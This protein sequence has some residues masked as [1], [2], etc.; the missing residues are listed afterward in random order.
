MMNHAPSFDPGYAARLLALESASEVLRLS[1][2]EPE[3][4]K[5]WLQPLARRLMFEKYIEYGPFT[6]S[7]QG[8]A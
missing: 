3:T 2:T 8:V 5:L 4:A 7:K 1:D 6:N